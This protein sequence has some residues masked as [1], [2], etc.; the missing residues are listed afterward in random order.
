MNASPWRVRPPWRSSPKA[1]QTP[2]AFG[3][4][5]QV[6]GIALFGQVNEETGEVIGSGNVFVHNSCETSISDGLC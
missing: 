4:E 6:I 1:P 3:P 5:G 2:C